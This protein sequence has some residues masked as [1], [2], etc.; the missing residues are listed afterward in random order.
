MNSRH[1]HCHCLRAVQSAST[2]RPH[3]R[4]NVD[5]VF[6]AK[7]SVVSEVRRLHALLFGH[8]DESLFRAKIRALTAFEWLVLD[9]FAP[10]GPHGR[11]G[12]TATAGSRESFHR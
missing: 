12:A 4:A 9:R 11:H 2:C 1:Y 3:V 8:L 10:G 5:F 7:T 6:A